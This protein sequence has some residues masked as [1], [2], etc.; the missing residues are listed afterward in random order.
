MSRVIRRSRIASSVELTQRA[1]CLSEK[2][3]CLDSSRRSRGRSCVKRKEKGR[4]GR[5][6]KG[7]RGR[8]REEGRERR[9]ER[10]GE[11]EG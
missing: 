7:E 5:E 6:R 8:E 10:G 11:G 9:G 1:I 3:S 2:P 4:E